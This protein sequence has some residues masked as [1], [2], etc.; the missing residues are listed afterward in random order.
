M[1]SAH[2]PPAKLG[3]SGLAASALE[4]RERPVTAGGGTDV[5]KPGFSLTALAAAIRNDRQNVVSYTAE[6]VTGVPAGMGCRDPLIAL[7]SASSPDAVTRFGCGEIG[8]SGSSTSAA[9]SV[10]SSRVKA[11]LIVSTCYKESRCF[12]DCAQSI[13]RSKALRLFRVL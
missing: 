12:G 9:V 6:T 8:R 1:A 13:G 2:Y 5:E 11:T 10:L 4:G 3:D 7:V